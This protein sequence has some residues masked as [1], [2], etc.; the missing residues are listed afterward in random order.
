[1]EYIHHSGCCPHTDLIFQKLSPPRRAFSFPKHLVPV[2]K[3]SMELNTDFTRGAQPSPFAVALKGLLDDTDFFTRDQWLTFI[4]CP[5]EN[6]IDLWLSD[7]ALPYADRLYMIVDLLEM[8]AVPQAP[9]KAFKDLYERPASEISPLGEKMGATL[10]D[11]M[12]DR[13]LS[14][15]G[16]TLKALPASEQIWS[17]Q[18]ASLR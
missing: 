2:Y 6:V 13:S 3:G 11:Y 5:K 7:K 9:V 12:N 17:L 4:G 1:M 10:S 14:R 16:A 18:N 8:R 15:L